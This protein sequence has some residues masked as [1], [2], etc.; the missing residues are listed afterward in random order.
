MECKLELLDFGEKVVK[1]AL[2]LGV[3]AVEVYLSL[4]STIY[5]EVERGKIVKAVNSIDEGF[6]VRVS[7]NKSLGF[8]YTNIL[9][10]E[11]IGEVVN[12]AF[13]AAKTVKPTDDWAGFPHPKQLLKAGG[14]YD[15][16]VDEALT[17]DIVKN[18][19]LMINSALEIDKR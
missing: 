12:K 2:K 16:K 5:V 17:E 11:K 3:G 18:A 4:A 19:F 14:I 8:S 9:K 15:K 1:E 7:Y 10:E 6:C 13:H